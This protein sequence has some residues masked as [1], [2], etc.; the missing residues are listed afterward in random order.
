MIIHK[1][2]KITLAS[3]LILA[4]TYHRD[5]VI[6]EQIYKTGLL[7]RPIDLHK[8]H[9]TQA[10]TLMITLIS[11]KETQFQNGLIEIYDYD[12]FTKN[13][14]MP[15]CFSGKINQ[16]QH[17]DTV[18]QI[19]AN[20]TKHLLDRIISRTYARQC[21][22]IWGDNHCGI[23]K[24]RYREHIQISYINNNIIHYD[25]IDGNLETVYNPYLSDLLGN[26]IPIISIDLDTQTFRTEP[27]YVFEIDQT[28]HLYAG[29]NRNQISCIAYDNFANYLGFL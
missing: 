14:I 27:L 16:T 3:E 19:Y 13:I 1:L 11:S 29:C 10:D 17:L 22:A 18:T 23:Q 28:Y 8:T 5:I 21:Q 24:S 9:T 20:S 4:T 12:M 26:I 25:V 2:V 15:A 6:Q 7:I